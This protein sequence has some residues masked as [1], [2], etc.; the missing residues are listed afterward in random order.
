M[1]IGRY[2]EMF[3]EDTMYNDRLFDGKEIAIECDSKVWQDMVL[4]GCVMIHALNEQGAFYTDTV[5]GSESNLIDYSEWDVYWK[6]EDEFKMVTD[7]VIQVTDL[8]DYV[9]DQLGVFN[10]KYTTGHP[11][12]VDTYLMSATSLEVAI[13]EY[14]KYLV[15]EGFLIYLN[16]FIGHRDEYSYRL[17]NTFI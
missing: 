9:K 6:D 15:D 8:W 14:L 11:D 4:H 2:K 1:L 10:I 12:Y 5:V 17:S 13:G 7:H 16:T 3:F